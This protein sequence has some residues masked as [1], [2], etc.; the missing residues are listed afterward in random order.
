VGLLRKPGLISSEA[1]MYL[2]SAVLCAVANMAMLL[3]GMR[4]VKERVAY[5][6][7]RVDPLMGFRD[8][9]KNQYA[10]VTLI[11]EFIKRFRDIASYMGVFLAAALLGDASKFILFGLPTGIGTFV[12]MLIVNAL[13]KKLNSKQIYILSGVYSILANAGA[14]FTGSLSFKHP[15]ETIYQVVFFAFLFLIGLQYGASNLL[16]EMFKSDILED[17]E[18]KTHKRLEVSLDFVVSIGTNIAAAI[19]AAAAPMVLYGSSFLNFIHYQPLTKSGEYV[20]QTDDTK[21]RL[22]LVYTTVQG[23]F[24]LLGAVP[25]LFYQLTGKRKEQVHEAVLAYRES[26][27]SE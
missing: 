27:S 17:I 14:Y 24:M 4:V 13:L 7:K 1:M 20:A 23:V 12:G 21:L 18:A 8:I 10:W 11:S 15:G 26:I 6:A 22:L 9:L 5:S 19:A 16:P 25:Y 3:A 2:V